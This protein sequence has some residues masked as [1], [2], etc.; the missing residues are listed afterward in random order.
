MARIMEHLTNTVTCYFDKSFAFSSPVASVKKNIGC[1]SKCL[2]LTIFFFLNDKFHLYHRSRIM[3]AGEAPLWSPIPGF[4]LGIL[5]PPLWWQV[6]PRRLILILKKGQIPPSRYFQRVG[7]LLTGTYYSHS[8]DHSG[9][10]S[11]DCES[12]K[13]Q[14][15]K[16][17][18][19]CQGH[20]SHLRGHRKTSEG[21]R[22]KQQL[23]DTKG[24][25][26]QGGSC[27]NS[28]WHYTLPDDVT[29]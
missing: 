24:A 15:P 26:A 7:P 28:R 13:P 4:F 8:P 9:E 6:A 23:L 22:A 29:S 12:W 2:F 1:P 16:Q 20:C 17:M 19:R 18:T 10:S 3:H 27:S 25:T 11:P 21:S 5:R 14:L